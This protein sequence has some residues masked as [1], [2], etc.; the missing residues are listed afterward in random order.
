MTPSTSQR[1]IRGLVL[2][3]A[4][5]YCAQISVVLASAMAPQQQWSGTL[6]LLV[7]ALVIGLTVLWPQRRVRAPV[8]RATDDGVV[9]HLRRQ[10]A[11]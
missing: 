2:L 5:L 3:V 4:G 11:L 1:L 9:G 6:W 10:G 7:P 8:A